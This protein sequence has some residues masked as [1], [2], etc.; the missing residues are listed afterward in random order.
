MNTRRIVAVSA[1]LS[2]PSST[3]MLADRLSAATADAL[4]EHGQD[5]TV[6]NG[7][8]AVTTTVFD[9]TALI[10]LVV[11]ALIMG[12]IGAALNQRHIF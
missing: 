5:A 11:I 8:G 4:R 12:F 9:W 3:R 6:V 7:V 2:Q 1:G 10:A